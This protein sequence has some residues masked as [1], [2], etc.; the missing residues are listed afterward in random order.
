MRD[1]FYVIKVQTG[2]ID[3]VHN[4]EEFALKRAHDL[5]DH[6]VG[7]GFEVVKKLGCVYMI[8]EQGSKIIGNPVGSKSLKNKLEHKNASGDKL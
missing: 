6:F 1:L 3:S 7:Q 2:Q 8:R 4:K 5:A